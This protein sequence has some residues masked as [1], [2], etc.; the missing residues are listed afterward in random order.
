MLLLINLLQMLVKH[1]PVFCRY[2]I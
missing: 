1:Y 2:A